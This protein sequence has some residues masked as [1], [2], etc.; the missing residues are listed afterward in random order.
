MNVKSSR[1][2]KA[3]FGIPGLDDILSGGLIRNRQYLFE[4]TPGS[5]KTTLALQF[6]LEGA[7]QGEKGLYITLSETEQELRD[8]ALSHDWSIPGNIGIFELKRIPV[9]LKHSLHGKNSLHILER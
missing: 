4:G 7:G 1:T 6:L 3:Q 9:I 2:T 5:G 8:T